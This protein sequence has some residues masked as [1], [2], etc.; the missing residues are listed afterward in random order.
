MT[1][2]MWTFFLSTKYFLS[3]RK[4]GMISL[5]GVISVIGV[6]LGVA[7]LIIVLSVMN[8]FD[9]EVRDKIIGTYAHVVIMRE[10]GIDGAGELI[11]RVEAMPE[12]ESATE[13][14]TGQGILR[15][16]ANIAGILIKGIDAQKE[17][18]VSAVIEYTD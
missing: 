10:G 9:L 16:G 14:V 18:E 13:F 5:I 11:S 6:A 4:E 12:V 8:G 15:S 3:K 17:S 1:K 2:T 7:S